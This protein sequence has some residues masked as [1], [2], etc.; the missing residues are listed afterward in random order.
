MDPT[1]LPGQANPTEQR[2]SGQQ[3]T[4]GGQQQQSRARG[5][6]RGGHGHGHQHANHHANPSGH[7]QHAGPP[8]V[9]AA[10]G[11]GASPATRGGGQQHSHAHDAGQRHAH[12]HGAPSPRHD[13]AHGTATGHNH[14]TAGNN[15]H[16]HN[17]HNSHSHSHGHGHG[18][19]H[20]QHPNHQNA[21]A[22]A[23]GNAPA[24]ANDEPESEEAAFRRVVNAF[25]AYAENAQRRIATAEQHMIVGTR[26][27]QRRHLPMNM[28]RTVFQQLRTA[29][30]TNAAFINEMLSHDSLF[31]L[32]DHADERVT[33]IAAVNQQLHGAGLGGLSPPT[34]FEL[35]KVRSTLKQFA[36]EWS[37]HGQAERD[38]SF[39][40][41]LDVLKSEFPNPQ[42]FTVLVPGTGLGRLT[43]EVAR[44]G[45]R[46]QGN[47]FSYYMLLASN[48][49]LNQVQTP[50]ELCPFITQ[51][52]NNFTRS[53][54]LRQITVPDV[55]LRSLPDTCEL[56][57][58]AGDFSA[59]YTEPDSWDAVVTCFFVDTAKN[60]LDY[61]ETIM[62]VL[63]PGG[64]WI[65]LGPLLYHFSDTPGETS[66]ELSFEELRHVIL[67]Y[68]FSIEVQ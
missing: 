9:A 50:L 61:V 11:G 28:L 53:L 25:R 18:H 46:A 37:S 21:A 23:A 55:D 58:S 8:A 35:D 39:N 6:G 68:G 27:E 2:R 10:A 41:I 44:A 63:Q 42:G 26:P 57:M 30:S 29:V 1:T 38:A 56:S 40:P 54:Q 31:D 13:H 32:Q 20:D 19:S 67:S 15:H 5:R 47:E 43:W 22:V 59:I 66:V 45:F 64:I 7:H 48:F 65:N 52:S 4:Q 14:G 12:H 62:N 60:I 51:F 36:R 17:N 34:E 24:P 3:G 33:Q 16:N 49:I